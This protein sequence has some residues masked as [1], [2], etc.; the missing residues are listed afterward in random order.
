ML[1]EASKDRF[2]QRVELNRG[3]VEGC[4]RLAPTVGM[5]SDLLLSECVDA[6]DILLSSREE[7][8]ECKWRIVESTALGGMKTLL[9][10]LLLQTEEG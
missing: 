9:W 5:L 3:Q 6:V 1:A 2:V 4:W 10:P 8:W 7:V